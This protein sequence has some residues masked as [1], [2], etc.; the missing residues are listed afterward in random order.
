MEASQ[1]AVRAPSGTQ[2]LGGARRRWSEDA[3]K[4]FL[5][6]CSLIGTGFGWYNIEFIAKYL[7]PRLGKKPNELRIAYIA[8][9]APIAAYYSYA[10]H[11][12]NLYQSGYV[13]ADFP[14]EAARIVE[15]VLGDDVVVEVGP[16]LGSL[17]LALLGVEVLGIV[18]IVVGL[19]SGLRTGND[20][21]HH[22]Y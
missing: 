11:P 3:V 12:V 18:A 13:S 10:M 1:S 17:T 20:A 14:G 7:A 8:E 16:G 4:A 21:G 22:H 9:G 2:V 15:R 19:C 5:I 6:V